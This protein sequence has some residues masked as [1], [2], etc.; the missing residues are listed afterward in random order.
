MNRWLRFT[1]TAIVLA[2]IAALAFVGP[3]HQFADYHSFADRRAWL[4]IP[5]AADVLSNA[6]FAIV[7]LWGLLRIGPRSDDPAIAAAWPGYRLFLVA[8]V[9]T[10]FGSAFYHWGPGDAR[11]ILDRIPIA[12]A[13]A[14]LLAGVRADVKPES[15]SARIAF[16]LALFGFASVLWWY[17]GAA[18]GQGDLRP[19]LLLQVLPIVLVPLWQA[20]HRAPRADRVA[21]GV[22]LALYA[23]AKV[24]EL[25]D[26]EVLGAL[27]WV[28][29]HTLKHLLATA[30]AAV[31]VAR[32]ASRVGDERSEDAA[33][34]EA[35]SGV[36]IGDLWDLY[37]RF[38][39]PAN[40]H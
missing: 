18:H 38:R 26:R 11:L 15:A 5:N 37:F 40:R 8:L 22:A 16:L 6:G 23:A 3:I 36:P 19:Y 10:A 30:A 34:A 21:F 12:L 17:A 39:F 32:L 33:A 14:G 4:G 9:L 28:S 31:L 1:P 13:C 27:H 7:G 2:A 25:G 35:S 24:A 20:I 29:G